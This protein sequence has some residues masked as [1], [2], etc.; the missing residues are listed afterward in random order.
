MDELFE[1]VREFLQPAG[2]VQP[3]MHNVPANPEEA[4]ALPSPQPLAQEQEQPNPPMLEIPP[5]EVNQENIL[6]DLDAQGQQPPEV[7][8]SPASSDS[9]SDAFLY[10]FRKEADVVT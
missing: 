1:V 7:D 9:E 3:N 8:P 5:S 10:D 6:I 2:E 4:P